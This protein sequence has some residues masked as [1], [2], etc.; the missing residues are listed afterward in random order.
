MARVSTCLNLPPSTEV[1]F[2][3]YKAV[4]GSEFA[5]PIMRFGMRW[6]FSYARTP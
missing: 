3:F 5:A 1:G 4:F 2:V 6:M